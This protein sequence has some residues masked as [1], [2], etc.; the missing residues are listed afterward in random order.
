MLAQHT[1]QSHFQSNVVLVQVC[2]QLFSPEHF[3]DLFKLIVVV[4]SLKKRLTVENLVYS[5]ITMPAIMTP[6]DQMS[7]E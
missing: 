7:N 1:L 3:C 6:S 2:V 4:R 5:T